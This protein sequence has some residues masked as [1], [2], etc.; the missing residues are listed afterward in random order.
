MR[1]CFNILLCFIVVTSHLGTQKIFAQNNWR[2]KKFLTVGLGLGAGFLGSDDLT[3]F[4]TTYNYVNEPWLF[5][6]LKGFGGAMI[7]RVELAYRKF[8]PKNMTFLVGWQRYK[9]RDVSQY[10][11]GD[12]RQL[13]LNMNGPY[14]DFEM[15]RTFKRHYIIN[16]VF[17]LFLNRKVSLKSN[18]QGDEKAGFIGK[19]EGFVPIAFD[20]G[21]VLGVYKDPVFLTC[22]ITYP[23]FTGGGSTNLYNPTIAQSQSDT[24]VIPSDYYNYVY[25]MG[26]EG[27]KS[28][29]DGLK[30][31]ITGAVVLKMFR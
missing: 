18:Y 29:I 25:G 16:G 21:V 10:N 27:I 22:K 7:F 5:S 13:E 24:P 30:I 2:P 17:T 6:P 15:G 12:M 3:H 19:Y 20:L 4:K 26:Y 9:N 8:G 1:K 31:L 23:L 14:V 28:N 11:N